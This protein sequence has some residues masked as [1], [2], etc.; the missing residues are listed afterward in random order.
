[1]KTARTSFWMDVLYSL[2]G[3]LI[4]Q[5]VLRFCPLAVC[6]HSICVQE[7]LGVDVVGGEGL[8]RKRGPEG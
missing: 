2:Y 4:W 7:A 3:I 5:I 8:E 1:M 6:K